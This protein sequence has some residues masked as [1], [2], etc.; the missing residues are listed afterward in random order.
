MIRGFLGNVFGKLIISIILILIITLNANQS[1]VYASGESWSPVDGGTADGINTNT[2]VDR[3]GPCIVSYNGDV[4]SAWCE[5]ISGND[6][7]R[8]MQYHSGTW[9]FIDGGT[10]NTVATD[11]AC[12][13]QMTVYNSELYIVWAETKSTNDHNLIHAKKYNGSSWTSLDVTTGK[14]YPC[15]NYSDSSGYTPQLLV[16]NEK[17]YAVWGEAYNSAS[18]IRVSRYDGGNTWTFVDGNGSHGLNFNTAYTALT[19]KAAAYN[20][21]LYVAWSENNASSYSQIRVRKY[22]GTPGSWSWVDGE[23]ANGLNYSNTIIASFPAMAAY[24]GGLYLTWQESTY[25]DDGYIVPEVRVKKYTGTPGSWSWVDGGGTAGFNRVANMDAYAPSLTVANNLLYLTWSE[26]YYDASNNYIPEIRVAKYNGA[27][28]AFIDGDASTGLNYYPTTYYADQQAG[29]PAITDN[30]GV[31]YVAWREQGRIHV[32]SPSPARTATASAGS[33]SPAA[34]GGN[35][36]TLT[37]KN[38]LGDTDA[39]FNGSK[40][41]TVSGYSAAPNGSY[42]SFNGTALTGTSTVVSVTFTNGVA[43]PALILNNATAQT[44]GFSISGVNTPATNTVSITPVPASPASMV[45][46]RDITA[47]KTNGGQFDQQPQVTLKDQFQNIC[48]NSSATVTASKYDSGSWTLTGTAGVSAASGV[49]SFSNLGATNGPAVT[50]ARLAFNASGCAQILSATVTLPVGQAHAPTIS[51]ATTAEDTQ[52]SSGLVITRN[53]SDGTEVTH[54]QITGITGGTL[55]KN[56]GTTVINNGDYITGAEGGA[57]LKFTPGA[58]KNTTAGDSF[59]FTAQAAFDSSGSCLSPETSASITVTEVNDAPSGQADTL[60]GIEQ[61][62]EARTIPFATLLSNDSKG[63]ANE[64]GQTLTITAVGSAVGGT[65]GISGTNMTFTPTSGFYGSAGFTYT[66]RDDGTTN[67]G[68][69]YKTSTAGVSFII[70]QKLDQNGLNYSSDNWAITPEAVVYNGSLYTV[71]VENSGGYTQIRCKKYNNSWSSADNNLSLN[72]SDSK[73]AYNPVLKVFGGKLYL[74]WYEGESSNY[75]VY[76]K[77]YDDST[78]WS[79]AQNL[80]YS[81]NKAFNVKLA[82]ASDTLYAVWAEKDATEGKDQVRVK[83]FQSG[84]SAADSGTLNYNPAM[85]ATLPNAE[86]LNNTLYVAWAENGM[87]KVKRYDGG[88]SWSSADDGGLN[89]DSSQTADLPVLVV[90]GSA[91]YAMWCEQN[92]AGTYQVRI[93]K[94]NGSGWNAA[95][96]S[97]NYTAGG[98]SM[99][100]GTASGGTLYAGWTEGSRTRI[101]T[102]ADGSAWS[103]VGSD[104]VLNY[105]TGQDSSG[106]SFVVY[107]SQ[108]YA[109]WKESDGTGSGL[110]QGY[111]IRLKKIP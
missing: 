34:G 20:N 15:L 33:S 18:Q 59:T 16:S 42:G 106:V 39:T 84:W 7:L 5:S 50:G 78:G 11:M 10:L 79:T 75:Q 98:A 23:T 28:R 90:N 19:P 81:A 100:N 40:S 97:L 38:S 62:S 108:I 32:K 107:N 37:V 73:N 95:S 72:N 3:T 26:L 86:V 80:S 22:N 30:N 64:S 110:T 31:L 45:L 94:Y 46:T 85:R 48:A 54:F 77:S 96:S 99:L 63:P 49:A 89:C 29:N 6:R 104:G 61:D 14:T 111:Q 103:A 4:Y 102:S 9:S 41:V 44:I 58:D 12:N 56:N 92:G 65:V 83:K 109:C 105:D 101:K 36:I 27:S 70:T 43:A 1:P 53:A 66:L 25:N 55:F 93:R 17:L 74:A 60:S 68:V 71:W 88:T 2:V 35:T 52:S 21:E 24:N 76:V 51:A 57:G 91:L 69:D 87:I 47:P 13:P 82:A 67:G 8:V